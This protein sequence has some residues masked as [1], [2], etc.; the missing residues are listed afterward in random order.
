[1]KRILGTFNRRAGVQ[2]AQPQSVPQGDSPESTIVR[3]VIA[4]CESSAPNSPTAGDE[5][6]HLPAIVDAAES[7]P[8]AAREGANCIRKFLTKDYASRAYAQ[9]NAV[10]LMRILSDNPGRS[11][12]RNFDA[13]FVKTVKELLREGQDL[14]VQQILRETLDSFATGKTD[15]ETLSALMEMWTKE[16]AKNNTKV[17]GNS[18]GPQNPNGHSQVAPSGDHFARHHRQPRSLPPPDELAA[19]I[20]EARTTAKLLSQ[21]VQS[22]PSAEISNNDLIKEFADRASSA[23]RSIQ[24]YIH[25]TNPAPDEDTLLTLI[26]TNDHLSIAMSKHQRALLQARRNLSN[27][28]SAAA[29]TPA[30]Q[31]NYPAPAGP[32][33]GSLA[34]GSTQDHAYPAPSSPPQRAQDHFYNPPPNMPPQ[35]AQATQQQQ[36]DA[37]DVPEN[38]FADEAHQPAPPKQSYGLF[39]RANQAGPPFGADRNLR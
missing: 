38:P 22:T 2:E 39:Q 10:M 6:L 1:M 30:D 20:E 5:F 33:P 12:T 28:S 29:S 25:S 14:S 37:Y 13:S 36:R 8:A 35:R 11:F 16:K 19:R 15:N 32:P 21:T 26:E 24:G 3:E 31:V 7:S 18:A 17:Y 27:S 9:Y 34:A 4:F 23:S